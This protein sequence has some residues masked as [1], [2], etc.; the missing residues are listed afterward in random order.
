[1]PSTI[2]MLVEGGGVLFTADKLPSIL[3]FTLYTDSVHSPEFNKSVSTPKVIKH[4]VTNIRKTVN[5][6]YEN[7][8]EEAV[9]A[10]FSKPSCHPGIF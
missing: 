2:F 8:W 7:T 3:H 5:N 9:M 1:M 4:L 6:T 10:Y